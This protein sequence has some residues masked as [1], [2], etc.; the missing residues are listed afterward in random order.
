MHRQL[1]LSGAVTIGMGSMIGA[2]LFAAFGPATAAAGHLL[3][4]SLILA[5]TIAICNAA[6]SAQLAAQYPTSGGTYVYGRERLGPWWGFAAGWCFLI[7]KTASAGAM[8]LTFG[9]YAAPDH[10]RLAAVLVLVAVTVINL[11]GITRTATATALILTI[12]LASAATVLAAGWNER[13]PVEVTVAEGSAVGVL[14][15]AGLLFF[16]FAGYARIATL[17]EE[18]KEPK[19]TIPRAIVIALALVL[20][21][22]SL[23]AFSLVSLLG[24]DALTSSLHP[25]A[26]LSTSPAVHAILTVGVSA[27]CAGS[28]LGVTAG[29]G[30]TGLAMAREGDLP[31]VLC[32]VR[33][34]RSPY[35]IDLALLAITIP[36]VLFVPLVGA[37][38][39]SSFGVLLYYA[40]ANLSALTQRRRRVVQW[41]GLVG[42]VAVAFSLP[43]SAIGSGLG[44]LAI[45]LVL[46][47]VARRGWAIPTG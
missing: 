11:A 41:I 25:L 23:V 20:V 16:A 21:L 43:L 34:G 24:I 17:G 13:S 31:R 26:D 2:G 1:G 15:G 5:A 18:V 3:P 40:V 4:L 39:F 8:A 35:R 42:C 22:Y 7:G 9:A 19:R 36:L 32:A 27:A 44:V 30:R 37:I 12:T 6:S 10:S 47:A 14:Q 45:G 28:L 29:I 46:R 38:G 33:E